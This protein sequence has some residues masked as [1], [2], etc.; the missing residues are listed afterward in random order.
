MAWRRRGRKPRLRSFPRKRESSFLAPGSR[1]RGYER[2]SNGIGIFEL[3]LN[4]LTAP[5]NAMRYESAVSR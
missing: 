3:S 2:T 4:N 1:F 5:A